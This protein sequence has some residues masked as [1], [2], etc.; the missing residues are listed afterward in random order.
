MFDEF[1]GGVQ[2]VLE[3]A[4]EVVHAGFS[5]VHRRDY[6]YVVDGVEV[7]FLRE[8]A[9]AEFTDEFGDACGVAFFD[10]EEVG[11]FAVVEGGEFAGVDTVSVLDYEAIAS[12]SEDFGKAGDINRAGAD[13]IAERV[14]GTDWGELVVV[15]HKDQH[16]VGWGGFEEVIEKDDIDH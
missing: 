15:A 14:A 4:V 1:C 3:D 5:L 9:D 13:D 12:L 8:S 6:L 2:G 7:V 16:T 10:K 11:A